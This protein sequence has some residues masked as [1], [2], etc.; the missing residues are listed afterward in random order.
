MA[1]DRASAA[2]WAI[3]LEK[4]G[5]AHHSAEEI[6]KSLQVGLVESSQSYGSNIVQDPQEPTPALTEQD[7]FDTPG[8]E[9]FVAH[10]Q[11]MGTSS[12]DGSSREDR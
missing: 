11:N 12:Y 5:F 9:P 3:E 8:S 1:T 7:S 10:R 6:K 2:S 4:N